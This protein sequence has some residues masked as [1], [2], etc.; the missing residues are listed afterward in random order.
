[1]NSGG[2][3]DWRSRGRREAMPKPVSHTSPVAR[4]TRILAGLTSLWIEAAPMQL[5]ERS[6]HADGQAQKL[7]QFHRSSKQS[8]QRLAARVGEYEHRPPLVR[9]ER[10]RPN[11]P[12]GIELGP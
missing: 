2:S 3:G 9:C 12:P 6:R 4:F 7:C 11:C 8:I 10:E 5:A 1:M